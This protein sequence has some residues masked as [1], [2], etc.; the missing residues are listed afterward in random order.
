MTTAKAGAVACNF[1]QSARASPI[2]KAEIDEMQ[3]TLQS[4]CEIARNE[5][6]GGEALNW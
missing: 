4:S 1:L 3:A 2:E 6:S 5:S